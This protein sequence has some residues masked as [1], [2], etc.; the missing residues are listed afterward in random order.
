MKEE[1]A[2]ELVVELFGEFEFNSLSLGDKLRVI[3]VAMLCP[4]YRSRSDV[5]KFVLL[6]KE[7]LDNNKDRD[8]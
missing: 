6:Y 8:I 4:K 7:F 2:T 3:E 5:V 1:E